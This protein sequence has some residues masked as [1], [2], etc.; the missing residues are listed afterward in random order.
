ML[1]ALLG[2]D[3]A[4]PTAVFAHNDLMALGALAALR[5]R[6]ISVPDDMSMV[7]YND[8]PGMDLVAPP[9][10]TVRYP[11]REIGRAAGELVVEL[12]AGEE[13]QSLVLEPALVVRQSTLAVE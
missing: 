2:L 13:P 10:T 9:L 7:G 11:S 5:R 8:L 6:D 3:A 4:T 1:E 12:L